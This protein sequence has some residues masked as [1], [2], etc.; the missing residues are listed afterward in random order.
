MRPEPKALW[1]TALAALASILA[2]KYASCLVNTMAKNALP[3]K[4]IKIK[5][6]TNGSVCAVIAGSEI[7]PNSTTLFESLPKVMNSAIEVARNPIAKMPMRSK[8][9]INARR[10]RKEKCRLRKYGAKHSRG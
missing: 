5:I 2:K 4:R 3:R 9:A 1:A 8:R 10:P 6:A 7:P